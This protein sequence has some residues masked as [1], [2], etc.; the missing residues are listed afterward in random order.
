MAMH[1]DLTDIRLFVHIS[2]T[3]SVTQGGSRSYMSPPAASM[4]IKN[5]EDS[6]GSKLLYRT[7]QG[8]SLTPAGQAFLY[9]AR[10]V[11]QQLDNLCSD[12]QEYAHGIKGHI[13]LFVNTS[14]IT[15]FIPTV[16]HQYLITH[17]DI[18]VDLKEKLSHDIVRAV[19][20]DT[21]DIGIIAGDIRT[22]NLQTI[23]YHRDRLI[24]VTSSSHPFSKLA[25]MSFSQTLEGDY[26][27]LNENSAIHSFLNQEA[28]K[29]KKT[30]KIRIQVGNFEAVCKMI[31]A[32]IGIGI[33]PE[34]AAKRYA[35]TMRICLIPLT[36]HWA[37]RNMKIC[38]RDLNALP[39]FAQEFI[40]MLLNDPHLPKKKS[41]TKKLVG[42]P[43]L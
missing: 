8:V 11:L 24:L 39:P 32:G 1:F 34:S 36:D 22:E 3:N 43:V 23:Q 10:L 27:G 42:E 33:L 35:K 14:A 31:E 9:H 30:V 7:S 18:Y 25:D 26:I 29:L 13:R 15:E 41:P 28:R 38:V 12:L 37:V 6:M 5:L 16:L 40:E 20:E 4:R 2:E 19:N 17:P 21:A